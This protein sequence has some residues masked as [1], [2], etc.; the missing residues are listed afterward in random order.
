MWIDRRVSDHD[1]DLSPGSAGLVDQT[2]EFVLAPDIARQA[3]HLQPL[4]RQFLLRR[5]DPSGV[6]AG[7]DDPRAM[8]SKR[9]RD[10]LADPFGRARDHGCLAGEVE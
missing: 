1:V 3:Q 10:R 2:L 5:H 9:P 6:A 4:V 8:V 7:D